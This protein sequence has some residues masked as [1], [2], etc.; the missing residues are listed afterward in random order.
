MGRREVDCKALPTNKSPAQRRTQPSASRAANACSASRPAVKAAP[1]PCTLHPAHSPLWGL[2]EQPRTPAAAAAAA[3]GT[4]ATSKRAN[5]HS[6]LGQAAEAS[7][8]ACSTHSR[9]CARR[10]Q[11]APRVTCRCIP[12]PIFQGT[13]PDTPADAGAKTHR[14][15]RAAAS[16]M[17]HRPDASRFPRGRLKRALLLSRTPPRWATLAKQAPLENHPADRHRA[18]VLRWG[19]GSVLLHGG[20]KALP[21]AFEKPSTPSAVPT[22]SARHLLRP[23]KII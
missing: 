16:Y 2:R 14:R 22:S 10:R 19:T 7:A 5:R 20:H 9:P 8:N 4:A 15:T 13:S 3:L 18:A 11:P 1:A 6:A 17:Q 21:R 23:Q 12:G